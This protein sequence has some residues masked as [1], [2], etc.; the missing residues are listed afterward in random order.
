MQKHFDAINIKQNCSNDEVWQ[1]KVDS[2][3]R[4]LFLEGN[5]PK[6]TGLS[7]PIKSKTQSRLQRSSYLWQKSWSYLIWSEILELVKVFIFGQYHSCKNKIPYIKQRK[8]WYRNQNLNFKYSGDLNTV[9]FW[10][11]NGW[12]E[13]GSHMVWF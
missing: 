2:Y 5:L 12:K 10:Y 9:L 13:V 7:L 4:W 6:Y 1:I 11:S 8:C 3:C